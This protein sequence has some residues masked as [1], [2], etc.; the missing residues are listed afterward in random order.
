MNPPVDA[1]ASRARRSRTVTANRSSPAANFSPPRDTNRGGSP[2]TWIGS[3]T[4][5]SR[6]GACAGLPPTR[7]RPAA[8]A[9]TA[10]RRLPSS[11]RRTSSVSSRRR[12]VTGAGYAE[13]QQSRCRR[14]DGAAESTKKAEMEPSR[15]RRRTLPPARAVISAGARAPRSSATNGGAGSGIASPPGGAIAAVTPDSTSA[16]GHPERGRERAVGRRAVADDDTRGAEARPDQPDRRGLGFARDLRRAP[17]RG[18][19][20]RDQG[21]RAGDQTIGDRVGR[22]EVGRHEPGA[23]PHRGR[24]AA[25]GRR[26]RT[27]GGNP[28]PLHPRPGPSVTASSPTAA[29]A[30]RTP[31]PAQAST[32]APGASDCASSHAAAVA[33]VTTSAGV[34]GMPIRSSFATTS[35]TGEFELFD[36]NATHNPAA[37]QR[38]DAGRGGRDRFVAP[39]HHT[40][41]IARHHLHLELTGRVTRPP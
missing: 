18:R 19:D 26:S 39:P 36:T 38:G 27:P 30:S 17:R 2:T 25:R 41:E 24:G 7:T 23:R 3:P 15:C 14:R 4:P 12:T 37:A 9:S 16:N 5:T 34:A 29:S 28:R 8:I 31:G 6:A 40:V 21:A 11:P 10:C 33:L 1:P 35:P 32:R 20:R 13:M 22:V